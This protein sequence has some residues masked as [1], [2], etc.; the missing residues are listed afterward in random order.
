MKS[1][2]VSIVI[3]LLLCFTSLLI[4]QSTKEVKRT[5]LTVMI[6]PFSTKGEN[7]REKIESDHNYRTAINAVSKAFEDR[8]FTTKDFVEAVKILGTDKIMNS[9]NQSDVVKAIQ[10]NAPVDLF[11]YT[12]VFIYSSTSGNKVQ[13]LLSAVDKYSADRLA[14]SE[15]MESNLM[16]SND[17]GKLTNQALTKDG[18]VEKFVNQLNVKFAEI[19]ENGRSVEVKIELTADS[20]LKLDDEIGSNYDILSDIIIDWV[21]KSAFKNYYHV[22]STSSKLLW[23][24]AIKVPIKDEN[25]N[26]L[27]PDDYARSFRKYLRSLSSQ[28]KTGELKVEYQILGSKIQFNIK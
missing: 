5:Q 25:G 4:A 11:V 3:L 18:A 28:V 23:F 24:D 12:E 27:L 26:N 15:P 21:K 7:I 16:Y 1:K 8:G 19:S 10:E 20:A 22:K 13:M 14:S 9:S 17:F 2:K 6:V